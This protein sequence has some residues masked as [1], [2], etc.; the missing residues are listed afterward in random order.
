MPFTG[1]VSATHSDT[2]KHFLPN[3]SQLQ[4]KFRRRLEDGVQW[5]IK[6]KIFS[7]DAGEHSTF[8]KCLF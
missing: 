1:M 4:N 7:S 2:A 3:T 8:C 6:G 5:K